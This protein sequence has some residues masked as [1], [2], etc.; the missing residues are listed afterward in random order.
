MGRLAVSLPTFPDIHII[1]G[2]WWLGMAGCRSDLRFALNSSNS[3]FYFAF[4]L[5][6]YLDTR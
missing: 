6:I 4:I 1:L 3:L 5:C 2:I